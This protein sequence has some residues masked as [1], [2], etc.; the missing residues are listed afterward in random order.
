MTDGLSANNCEYA[1][2][3]NLEMGAALIEPNDR[4]IQPLADSEDQHFIFEIQ[5][6]DFEQIKMGDL[7]IYLNSTTP[8]SLGVNRLPLFVIPVEIELR[9]LL[10]ISL[11]WL[12][13][14]SLIAVFILLVVKILNHRSR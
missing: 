2:E 8:D 3:I 6:V 7:W 1:F 13:F 4:L 9:S 11:I 10:G 12:R 14:I 5:P